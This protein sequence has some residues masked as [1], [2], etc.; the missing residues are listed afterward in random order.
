MIKSEK[1]PMKAYEF[2]H[3]DACPSSPL[4]ILRQKMDALDK[5]KTKSLESTQTLEDAVSEFVT[6]DDGLGIF[7][8]AASLRK[9]NASLKTELQNSIRILWPITKHALK[10]NGYLP[11]DADVELVSL[12]KKTV[13]ELL[14]LEAHLTEIIKRCLSGEGEAHRRLDSDG[15]E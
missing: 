2:K 13:L 15:K 7:E 14:D 6:P 5:V 11:K 9:Q 3:A 1:N 10:V 12:Q 8:D 4:G